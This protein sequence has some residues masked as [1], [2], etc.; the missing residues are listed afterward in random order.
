MPGQSGL[1]LFLTIREMSTNRT[2]PVVFVTA[3]SDFSSRAQSTFSGG[4]DFIA[5]PFLPVELAVKALTHLFKEHPPAPPVFP[6]QEA[7]M[8]PAVS[9]TPEREPKVLVNQL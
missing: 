4:T 7:A 3:H 8:P 6:G 1:D 9:D 2:T 5:K